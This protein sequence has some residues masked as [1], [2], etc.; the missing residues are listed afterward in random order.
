MKRSALL[1]LFL[2]SAITLLAAE[3][4]PKVDPNKIDG[5]WKLSSEIYKEKEYDRFKNAVFIFQGREVKIYLGV[6]LLGA[7]TINHDPSKKPAWLDFSF[8]KG[9][10]QRMNLYGIYE[11][12]GDELKYRWHKLRPT[13]FPQ[14]DT[15]EQ[16]VWTLKREKDS[17]TLLD[18]KWDKLEARLVPRFNKVVVSPEG[19][20]K[21]RDMALRLEIYEDSLEDLRGLGVQ[22]K[23]FVTFDGKGNAQGYIAAGD[24]R[25][26]RIRSLV[27][28]PVVHGNCMAFYHHM[29]ALDHFTISTAW[30]GLTPEDQTLID[31]WG[32]RTATYYRDMFKNRVKLNMFANR[33]RYA[34]IHQLTEKLNRNLTADNLIER[35]QLFAKVGYHYPAWADLSRGVAMDPERKDAKEIAAAAESQRSA[36]IQ[37][38]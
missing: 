10:L 14:K 15:D 28:A 29:I 19:N 21:V 4:P 31:E 6:E 22:E 1:L 30:D 37:S 34:R 7:G 12:K 5:I 11:R 38:K 26:D 9:R 17:E 35:G 25:F 20:K 18:D 33:E 3:T 23:I 8:S 24:S 27:T 16:F 32:K 2:G 36:V 13:G